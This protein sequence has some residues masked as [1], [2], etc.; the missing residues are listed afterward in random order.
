MGTKFRK[1][2]LTWRATHI[3][4]ESE[5]TDPKIDAF[6]TDEP[7]LTQLRKYRKFSLKYVAERTLLTVKELKH[8]EQT[9][10]IPDRNIA[11]WLSKTYR[12]TT[13]LDMFKQKIIDDYNYEILVLK[14]MTEDIKE[15]FLKK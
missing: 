7:P 3:L 9:G 8:I 14:V 15:N 6:Y 2:E 10:I 11:H 5:K 12:K 4:E 13:P 1:I